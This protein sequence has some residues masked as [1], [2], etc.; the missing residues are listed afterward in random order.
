MVMAESAMLKTGLKKTKSSPI[1]GNVTN[2]IHLQETGI[3]L[4][5]LFSAMPPGKSLRV[6]IP[7]TSLMLTR[8]LP[9]SMNGLQVPVCFI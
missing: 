9:S 1:S 2:W 5:L 3:M 8:S 6:S 7:I 4:N